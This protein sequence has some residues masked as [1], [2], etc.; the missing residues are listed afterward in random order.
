MSNRR[1]IVEESQ[2]EPGQPWH[3]KYRPK[4]WKDV[5]GQDAVVDSLRKQLA[6]KDRNHSYALT[7]PSGTGKTTLARIAASELGVLASNLTE[8][9][10]ASNTGIDD[11][12]AVVAPLRYKGFGDA[13]N[14]AVIIDEAHRL[15]KQA[16]DSLLKIVEEPPEH[17]YFFFCTTEAG[18]IPK[19]IETRCAAYSLRPLGYDDLMDLLEYVRGKEDLPTTNRVLELIAQSCDGS[20]RAALVMLQQAHEAKDEE[21]AARLFETALDNKEVIDLAR[22]LVSGKLDWQRLT[23]TLKAMPEMSAESIRIIIVA[24]LASCLMGSKSEN[25]TIRLLDMLA[26]FSKP[27]PAT[28]KLA[29]LLLSFGAYIYP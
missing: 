21:E 1:T 11:M 12:R 10:A 22:D 28:D 4:R 26:A 13:P 5:Q 9:D 17:V 8:I 23:S 3:L 14:K 16:W 7:G 15:S 20:P 2:E 29:P 6:S 24:Y 19:A 25:S 18:K 27:Y